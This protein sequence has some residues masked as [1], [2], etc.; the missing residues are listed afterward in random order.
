MLWTYSNPVL[1]ACTVFLRF[2]TLARKTLFSRSNLL[3][4]W[5]GSRRKKEIL[6]TSGWTQACEL[7][8]FS[9]FKLSVLR[10]G[11]L[12]TFCGKKLITL[13]RALK[14]KVTE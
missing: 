8:S 12:G 7:L 13:E 9:G 14:N 11:A 6:T 5:I 3:A 1:E 10:A 4:A 2:S